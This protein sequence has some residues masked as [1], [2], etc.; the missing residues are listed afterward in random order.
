M[1]AL[2]AIAGSAAAAIAAL[3][4]LWRNVRSERRREEK[5][6]RE[7]EERRA[8]QA[9]QDAS[10]R[11]DVRVRAFSDEVRA[12]VASLLDNGLGMV[13][14]NIG[15]LASFQGDLEDFDAKL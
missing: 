7:A 3:L 2:L 15:A 4:A 12:P 10:K 1:I 5:E 8:E 13:A 14:A 6:R 9:R 11:W